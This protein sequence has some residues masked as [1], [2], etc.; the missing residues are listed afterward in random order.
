MEPTSY[1]HAGGVLSLQALRLTT[2][3]QLA[4]GRLRRLRLKPRND[5][6][7]KDQVQGV[8]TELAGKVQEAAGELTGNREQEAKG[9]LKQ[10]E[11][12]GQKALG[13]AKEIV[14]DASK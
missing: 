4:L 11:G 3:V 10:V 13:D 7:N 2:M 8:T 6:M 9:I 5:D 12:K 1:T 14:K